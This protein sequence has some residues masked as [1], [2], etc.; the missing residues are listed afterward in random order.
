MKL[1]ALLKVGELSLLYLWGLVLG[2]FSNS[3]VP[4]VLL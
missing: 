1:E 3:L 4:S 2:N